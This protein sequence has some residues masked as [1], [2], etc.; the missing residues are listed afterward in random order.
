MLLYIFVYLLIYFKYHWV[1][2]NQNH[3]PSSKSA[4]RIRLTAKEENSEQ[5]I[6]DVLGC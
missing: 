4:K 3:S 6:G 2:F 1:G 5:L